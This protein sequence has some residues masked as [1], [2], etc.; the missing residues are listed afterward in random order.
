MSSN[1]E[2]VLVTRI[3]RAFP[4][5]RDRDYRTFYCTAFSEYFKNHSRCLAIVEFDSISRRL[6][7]GQSNPNRTIRHLTN[8]S[9]VRLEVPDARQY[10]TNN[11]NFI[12]SFPRSLR[13]LPCRMTITQHQKPLILSLQ[14]QHLRSKIQDCR[15][16]G[17]L[18]PPSQAE[19]S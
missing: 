15:F 4:K 10:P 19:P 14:K 1:H 12:H 3:D 16:I 9:L 13:T 7:H 8:S 2:S 11:L 6:P 17:S 18:C 5:H